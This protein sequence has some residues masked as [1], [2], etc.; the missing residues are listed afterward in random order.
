MSESWMVRIGWVLCERP[1][2]TFLHVQEAIHDGV[3]NNMIETFQFQ[4]HQRSVSLDQPIQSAL[5]KN[6]HLVDRY[7]W[8]GQSDV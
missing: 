5:V 3:G 7:P 2:A 1:A 4:K 6:E 8:T